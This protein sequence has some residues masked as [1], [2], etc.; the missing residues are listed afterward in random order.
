MGPNWRG[1]TVTVAHG[2]RSVRVKLVDWCGSTT[3]L[4]DLYWEPMRRLGGTGTLS[5]VVRW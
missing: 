3:K 1:Q 2:S 4:I 5:V